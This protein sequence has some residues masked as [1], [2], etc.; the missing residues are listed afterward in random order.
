MKKWRRGVGEKKNVSPFD[1]TRRRRRKRRFKLVFSVCGTQTAWGSVLAQTERARGEKQQQQQQ[2][3]HRI[4]FPSSLLLLT[5]VLQPLLFQTVKNKYKSMAAIDPRSQWLF[6][7][8]SSSLPS[9]CSPS[10]STR[11]NSSWTSRQQRRAKRSL[12]IR[13]RLLFDWRQALVTGGAKGDEWRNITTGGMRAGKAKQRDE[14]SKTQ[15]VTKTTSTAWIRRPFLRIN[16][17]SPSWLSSMEMHCK[18]K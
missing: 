7:L 4:P 3:R 8:L 18:K 9:S 1:L 2:A 10:S 5:A 13:F 17:P 12:S 15:V 6:A 16:T 11:S 14:E